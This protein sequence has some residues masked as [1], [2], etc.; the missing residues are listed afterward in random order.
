MNVLSTT[1]DFQLYTP[2]LKIIIVIISVSIYL[3]YYIIIIVNCLQCVDRLT[4]YRDLCIV[5]ILI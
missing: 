1:T 3:N 2:I 5:I 4:V